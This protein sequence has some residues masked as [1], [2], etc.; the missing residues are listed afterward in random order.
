[1]FGRGK[2]VSAWL[3]LLICGLVFGAPL[4]AQSWES[5]A[6]FGDRLRIGLATGW[7]LYS[8]DD[9]NKHY[10]DGFAKE[11]GILDDNI[12]GGPSIYGEVSYFFTP[13]I[14]TDFGV[15][16]LRGC[17]QKKSWESVLV[18]PGGGTYATRWERALTTTALAPQMMVK[19]H[20]PLRD[21]DLFSGVGIAWC[22]GKSILKSDERI[23]DL[24]TSVSSEYRYT[25]QGLGLLG[26]IGM[27]HD[28]TDR[29]AIGTEIGYRH[30]V[31]GNL[32]DPSGNPWEVEYGG[33][34]HKMDLDFSGAFMLVSLSMRL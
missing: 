4:N 32:E 1:M 11:M 34:G 7:G 13:R 16:Y 6:P 25:A 27:S 33:G 17:S 10:I 20:F 31:T 26:S 24:G 5:G 3:F 23:P 30:F 21:L 15:L 12:D 8:M 29:F 9:V 22:W 18:F 28:L 19:Y 2:S 14:S